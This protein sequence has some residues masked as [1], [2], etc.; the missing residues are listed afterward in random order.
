MRLLRRALRSLRAPRVSRRR[1]LLVETFEDRS[2]PTVS[3]PFAFGLGSNTI[4][5]QATAVDSA[6]NLYIAGTFDGTVDFDPGPGVTSL[7]S[8]GGNRDIF[9]AKYS[10]TGGLL[11]ARRAGDTAT[12][13]ARGLAI[14]NAGNV[15][16]TGVFSGQVNFNPAGNNSLTAF[17]RGDGFV[18]KLDTD[19]KFV[20]VTPIQ[21]TTGNLTLPEAITVDRTTGD[22]YVA[23]SFQTQANF[24]TGGTPI[25]INGVASADAFAA[26]LNPAGQFV[27]ARVFASPG[28]ENPNVNT[29]RGIAV[30]TAGNVTV[31]GDF[32]GTIDAD[33]GAGTTNLV[34]AGGQ[35]AFVIKLDSAGDFTY[36]HRIGNTA[37]DTAWDVVNDPAG[38]A[39]ITGQFSN[40]VD[41]DPG[42]GT[43]NLTRPGSTGAYVLKLT[44]A[45]GLGFVTD[46]ATTNPGTN[47][48]QGGIGLDAAGNIYA[49]TTFVGTANVGGTSLSSIGD[50]DIA[51]VRL[52][53]GGAIAA[54]ARAGGPGQDRTGG[55]YVNAAGRIA[56]VGTY[57]GTA[58][59]GGNSLGNNGALNTFGTELSL[60]PTVRHAT[61]SDFNGDGKTDLGVYRP[62]SSR[63]LSLLSGGG[64][65]DTTFGAPNLEDIPVPG[66]YDGDGKTDLAV[67]RPASSRWL[68]LLSGGGVMDV[69]FGAPNL[70]DIPAPGDYDG[71]SKTDLAVF[72]PSEGRWLAIL[73][74]GGVL[75]ARFGAPNLIDIPVPADYDGDGRTDLAVFR[76]GEARWL[77]VETGGTVMNVVFGAANYVDIPIPG[78]YDGDGKAD[79]AVYRPGTSR[80]LSLESGGGVMDVAF[81]AQNLVDIPLTAPIGVLKR[82]N[83]VPV[84]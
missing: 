66:D 29:G 58:Q 49:A 68:A 61:I 40:T 82:L 79:L 60:T 67:F 83:R 39:Y 8:P 14:D 37:F 35:D 69:T 7:T 18:W 11:W 17:Q 45:G 59:F 12:D 43:V 65:L 41:F 1:Q 74:G 78:D 48:G 56:L 30:D 22:A 54:A 16:V 31:V 20:Y 51:V 75:D 46:L 52:G 9:V 23:G 62:A 27:W 42:A 80:W 13:E 53:P 32:G 77:S 6:N 50:Q 76:P 3:F 63:W 19:G 28:P 34:S 25:T 26:H 38:N 84:R 21:G 73:T 57:V 24:P 71:D 44:G 64:V 10:S 2:L 36:G 4:A 81:G 15:Y 55:L 47:P 5:A 72:R 70:F 33:P